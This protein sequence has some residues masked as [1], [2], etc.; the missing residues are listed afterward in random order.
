M[1]FLSC[2]LKMVKLVQVLTNHSRLMDWNTIPTIHLIQA[3]NNKIIK[4]GPEKGLF[5]S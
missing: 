4:Q 2:C 1:I 3:K 5:K